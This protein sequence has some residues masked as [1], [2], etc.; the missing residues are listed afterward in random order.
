MTSII[1]T[2]IIVTLAALVVIVVQD[3]RDLQA[4]NARL[5]RNIREVVM[6]KEKPCLGYIEPGEV[7]KEIYVKKL[8]K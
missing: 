2:L 5:E 3:N 8:V 1:K 4:R 7:V 6:N